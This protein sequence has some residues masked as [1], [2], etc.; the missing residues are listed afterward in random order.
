MR[1]GTSYFIHLLL[2]SRMISVK[3][4]FMLKAINLQTVTHRELPDCYDF[5]VNVCH[6]GCL[7]THR[8]LFFFYER[9][10]DASAHMTVDSTVF[11]CDVTLVTTPNPK[12]LGH[13]KIYIKQ[14]NF[15]NY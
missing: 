12:K 15:F 2:S 1:M 3:I 14:C 9:S 13:C 4:T 5:T 11:S 7:M 6:L 8:L 10:Y